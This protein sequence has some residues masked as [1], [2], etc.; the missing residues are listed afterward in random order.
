MHDWKVWPLQYK[1]SITSSVIDTQIEYTTTYTSQSVNYIDYDNNGNEVMLTEIITTP[2]IESSSI[3][4]IKT[5]R[6]IYNITGSIYEF[7]YYKVK[8]TYGDIF[9]SE[10]IIDQI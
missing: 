3:D 6:D 2:H 5:K 10:N 7:C 1:Y 8:E 4:I 9:G